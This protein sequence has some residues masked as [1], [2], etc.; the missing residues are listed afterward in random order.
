[1]GMI[2]KITLLTSA[3][4]M[5]LSFQNC[6]KEDMAFM[7]SVV[8]ENLEYFNYT[9]KSAPEF[10][11]NVNVIPQTPVDNYKEFL[12]VGGVAASDADRTASISWSIRML[13][14]EGRDICPRMEGDNSMGE[15]LIEGSCVT[16]QTNRAHKLE[17]KVVFDGVEHV[18][19]Q[20]L[21]GL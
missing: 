6:G 17:S 15:T 21:N 20:S 16:P 19:T 2:K 8:D 4:I 12:I 14:A 7:D 10:Y 13:D 5:V 1:M 18:F 3:F 9:Y 11:F